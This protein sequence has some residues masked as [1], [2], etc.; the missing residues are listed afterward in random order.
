MFKDKLN[1]ENL[2]NLFSEIE[3]PLAKTL[4]HMELNGVS[5]N[6]DALDKMGLNFKIK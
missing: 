1:E 6:V 5:I 3:I 2:Y 4:A